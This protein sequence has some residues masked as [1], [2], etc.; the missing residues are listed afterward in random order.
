MILGMLF[1]G[2]FSHYNVDN[3]ASLPKLAQDY[4]TTIKDLKTFFQMCPGDIRDFWRS[5]SLVLFPL[6]PSTFSRCLSSIGYHCMFP[7]LQSSV[8]LS[9]LY[10]FIPGRCRFLKTGA[11]RTWVATSSLLQANEVN[12][13]SAVSTPK[14]IHV[15]T[16]YEDGAHSNL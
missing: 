15:T 12:G 16:F 5:R 11:Q 8:M 13:W 6:S 10:I 7:L 1:S 4:S 14:S 3:S 2:R 9:S